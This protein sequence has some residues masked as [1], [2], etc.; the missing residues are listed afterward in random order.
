M[1][2][3]I[4]YLE[5]CL[6]L[7]RSSDLA[8]LNITGAYGEAECASQEGKTRRT[9]RRPVRGYF[10]RGCLIRVESTK[11]KCELPGV[12]HAMDNVGSVSKVEPIVASRSRDLH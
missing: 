12:I 2:K 7:T 8:E 9:S 4:R 6:S 5:V 1:N 11:R 3:R 10:G